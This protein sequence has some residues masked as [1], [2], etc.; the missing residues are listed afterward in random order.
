[1]NKMRFS[2]PLL[3]LAAS[4]ALPRMAWAQQEQPQIPAHEDDRNNITVPQGA[5]D[6]SRHIEIPGQG[7]QDPARSE[8][9]EGWSRDFPRCMATLTARRETESEAHEVCTKILTDLGE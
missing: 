2:I 4:L 5:Y 9:L 1:M 3:V 7:A 8:V 6:E